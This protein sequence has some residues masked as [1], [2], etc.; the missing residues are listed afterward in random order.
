VKAWKAALAAAI[1]TAVIA[2]IVIAPMAQGGKGH[3]GLNGKRHAGLKVVTTTSGFRGERATARCPRGF[4]ATG[5]GFLVG[6][7]VIQSYK[8]GQ[9]RWRVAVSDNAPQPTADAQVV[10]AKGTGGFKVT[11]AG[12]AG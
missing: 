8:L 7:G 11:D 4:V 2:V 5:G 3:A 9:R 1:T 6:E 12:E 10:C